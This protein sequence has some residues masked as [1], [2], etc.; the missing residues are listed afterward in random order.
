MPSRAKPPRSSP[1]PLDDEGSKPS[2]SANED[3]R[4]LTPEEMEQ[5]ERES[6]AALKRFR[7]LL[8]QEKNKNE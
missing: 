3:L 6:N 2:A 5:L 8:A 7:Y 4:P 1:V